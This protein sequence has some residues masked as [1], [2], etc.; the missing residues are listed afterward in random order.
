MASNSHALLVAAEQ[1]EYQMSYR[2]LDGNPGPPR[3]HSRSE[4]GSPDRRIISTNI[5]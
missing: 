1:T 4:T 5:N 2:Q 3:S